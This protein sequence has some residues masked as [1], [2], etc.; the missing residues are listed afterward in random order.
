MHAWKSQK[1]FE[2]EPL[3]AQRLALDSLSERDL[4]ALLA[5]PAESLKAHIQE[6]PD[7]LVVLR[8][9]FSHPDSARKPAPLPVEEIEADHPLAGCLPAISPLLRHSLD[10]LQERA[11]GLRGDFESVPFEMN[12]LPRVFLANIAPQ[13]LFQLSKPLLLELHVARLEGHLRGETPEER[14]EDFIRR[15]GQE[16][17][18]GS[19]VRLLAKYPVLARQLVLTSEQWADYLSEFLTRLCA[20]WQ[21]I[22]TTFAQGG[23]P[24]PLVDVE[25]DKG[26]RHR[27]G[28]SVLLL[29]FGSGLKLLYKPRSLG[30]D[31]H[32][33]E[34]LSWLND[35]GAKPSLR[36]LKLV[37]RG[38]HGWSEFIEAASCTCEEEVVRFYERQGS[39]LA[40]LY[41]LDASDLHNENL[42][43]AG[44]HPMP[45]DLEALFHP[46]V[47]ARGPTQQNL[48]AGALD[49]S[50]WQ[51]GLLPRRDWSDQDSIGVDISGLGGQSG[52][53]N[54]HPTVSWEKPG[55]DEMR[56][57]RRRA[58]LPVSENR[59]RLDDQDVEVWRYKDAVL[60]G[61]TRM[62]RLLCENRAALL[63]EQLPRFAHDE[64][65]A[66]LR[67]TNVYGLL[68]YESF[69]PD[70]LRDALARDRFYDHL[71]AQAAQRPYLVPLIPAEQRD[72]WHGDI[73]LFHTCPGS[74]ALLTAEGERFED[75]FDAPSLD[76]VQQ[77]V[78]QL[79]DDDLAKQ[80]WIIEASMA[81]L[82]MDR[83][84]RIGRPAHVPSV[85]QLSPVTRQ[86]EREHLLTLASSV[87]RR[88]GE[89]SLQNEDGAHWLGV[90]P[91][92][93]SAWGLFPSGSD[94]YSGAS[95]IALSLGYLGAITGEPA[96]TLLAHRALKSVRVQVREWLKLREQPD[97]SGP[98]PAVGG[99][100]GLASVIYVL[101][102]LGVLWAEQDLLDDAAE[103]VEGLP[104]AISR[105]RSLDIVYGSAGCILSL[106]SLHAVRPSPRTLDAAIRCGERLLATAQPAHR[107]IAWATLEDQPPLGGFSHGTTGIALSLLQLAA[108]SSEHRFRR[109]ALSALGY[110][111][112]LFIPELN[113]WAD[114]RVFEPRTNPTDPAPPAGEPPRKSMV[115]WCHG[116]AG[117][118]LA[119][120]A[121][122]DQLADA[123][124]R[125][126][127]D[128]ALSATKQYGFA[129]NHSLCHG[130][131]GNLELLLM[132]ARLLNR[133]ED[134][135]ALERATRSVVASMEA[136]GFVAGV[137]LGV[138]TPGFMT[139]LAG[140]GYELLRLAEPD[141]VPSVLLL[142]PPR[143][144]AQG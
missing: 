105:D 79:G 14:F 2:Q 114:L 45:V 93:D 86:V 51:V 135:D 33:Q 34:L 61:F 119:R 29:R 42:L 100:D 94:L 5:E 63:A 58:E 67:S 137:P 81:T 15:L 98:P 8:Q 65:R 134:H 50:V 83:E 4:L 28:R 62:Y 138:E 136:N 68:W 77:R 1:P 104:S 96:V 144:Q 103:L 89:L 3:F 117:I 141:K 60:A 55:T 109:A 110:D 111:R 26:D 120:L 6:P 69:H 36:P 66:V 88:L 85:N 108:Q 19:V 41:A 142:A 92:D 16:A 73:P 22:R 90:G 129:M 126:D 91:L 64:T 75:F 39:Y 78:A 124:T 24:G 46:Q 128:I 38:N 32:F 87:G 133:P 40:L 59:P 99:F 57:G 70:L 44:E 71:W 11:R 116:A 30:V 76:L 23:D 9:A 118:G 54:P 80:R 10:R 139:G 127:I 112:S 74:R 115:A 123:T 21:S 132:A 18:T 43:A 20:D 107:G 37:D 12:V 130:A 53:L 49:R 72:L 7:W 47:R 82:L 52:Q 17:S 121:A 97:E 84:D 101:T 35:R 106:L 131:L 25:A 140:I 48:A 95:G 27:R 31:V 113:N 122:L 125:D 13:I 56:V 102:N 143:W